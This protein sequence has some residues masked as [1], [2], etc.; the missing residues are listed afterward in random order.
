[1]NGAYRIEVIQHLLHWSVDLINYISQSKLS[2]TP[3]A[4]IPPSDK[5]KLMEYQIPVS[6]VWGRGPHWGTQRA[7]P[8]RLSQPNW[9][10]YTK[11]TIWGSS[12]HYPLIAK[13][14][15]YCIWKPFNFSTSFGVHHSNKWYF[16]RIDT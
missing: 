10:N 1:M 3:T 16:T 12:L 4:I 15:F 13:P 9:Q 7:Q 2:F 8:L 6:L 14:F 5:L 11:N